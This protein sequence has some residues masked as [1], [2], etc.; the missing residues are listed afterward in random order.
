MANLEEKYLSSRKRGSLVL[1]QSNPLE[2]NFYSNLNVKIENLSDCKLI[3]IL[4][5]EELIRHI[6]EPK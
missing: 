1:I 5:L 6:K 2:G 4:E 3:E